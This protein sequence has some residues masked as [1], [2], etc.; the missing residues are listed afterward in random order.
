MGRDKALLVVE[1]EPLVSRVAAR[2]AAQTGAVA[3]AAGRDTDRIARLGLDALPDGP[4][5]AGPLAGIGA[6]LAHARARGFKAVLTAPCDGAFCPLDLRARLAPALPEAGVAA[7]A[8]PD[9]L[10][11][12]FALWGVEAAPVVAHALAQGRLAVR[13]A[14]AAAGL[15]TLAVDR[16]GMAAFRNLNSPT[17]LAR[18]GLRLG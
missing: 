3:V 1:G 9:G 14:M 17:D 18:S 13:D 4:D 7:I 12:L 10:E 2:L 6:G 5:G 11:P 16:E 8:G 15:A